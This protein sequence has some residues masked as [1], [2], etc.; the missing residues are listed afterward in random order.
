MT[1]F[2]LF[3]KILTPTNYAYQIQKLLIPIYNKKVGIV[4]TFKNPCNPTILVTK[5][6]CHTR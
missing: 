2:P 5:R 4:E 1:I 6:P 3:T